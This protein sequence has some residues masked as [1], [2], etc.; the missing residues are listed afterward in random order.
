MFFKTLSSRFIIFNQHSYDSQHGLGELPG[1]PSPAYKF[2][3]TQTSLLLKALNHAHLTFTVELPHKGPLWQLL[4]NELQSHLAIY[5]LHFKDAFKPVQDFDDLP[6]SLLSA[7]RADATVPCTWTEPEIYGRTF[8][9]DGL[10]SIIKTIKNPLSDDG[11]L[12]LGMH[13]IPS[14]INFQF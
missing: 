8:T 9:M 14:L 6:W 13:Y 5:S 3:S 1:Y 7:K 12:I 10:A 11:L 2:K 4:H